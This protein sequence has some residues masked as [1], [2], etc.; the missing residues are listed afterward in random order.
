M[1]TSG[2]TFLQLLY[3]VLEG[4]RGGYW[5]LSMPGFM[6]FIR[7]KNAEIRKKSVE[8]TPEGRTK[9][10]KEKKKGFL[11][12]KRWD[13]HVGVVRKVTGRKKETLFRHESSQRE[14]RLAFIKL[15]GRD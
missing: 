4:G 9:M 15:D 14:R 11:S 13:V 2:E 5:F 1:K 7:K 8:R 12:R 10:K 3:P 6:I